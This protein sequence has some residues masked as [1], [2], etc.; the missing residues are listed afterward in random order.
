MGEDVNYYLL[1]VSVVLGIL[2]VKFGPKLFSRCK[3]IK[4]R[5]LAVVVKSES[6]DAPVRLLDVRTAEEFNG[7]SGYIRGSVNVPMGDLTVE[8]HAL[9]DD[10]NDHKDEPVYII[11]TSGLR[12]AKA[13]RLLKKQGFTNAQVLQGG[14]D[15]WDNLD[16]PLIRPGMG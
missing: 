3:H 5:D 15:A 16:Y 4:A 7:P 10:L 14:L 8:I 13:A 9:S 11:C 1:L 6:E 2:T 12:S